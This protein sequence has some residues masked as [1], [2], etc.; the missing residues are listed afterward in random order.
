MRSSLVLFVAGGLAL[1]GAALACTS[2]DASSTVSHGAPDRATF[3]PVARVLVQRCGSIDC[4]G[5]YYRNMRLFGFGSQR[6]D[7]TSLPDSP[8]DITPA[9]V[10]ADFDTVVGLEPSIM[11]E[12]LASGGRNASRLTF[13][14]K[15]RGQEAHK[16]GQR[17]VPG[18][19]ADACVLSWLAS[20]VD[21]ESCNAALE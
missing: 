18:D 20:E 16:G 13:I 11:R 4:H 10:D 9:E 8:P 15:A 6:L 14:R 21:A 19:S 7:P 2:P 5:S 1:S 17:I 3:T 12:V